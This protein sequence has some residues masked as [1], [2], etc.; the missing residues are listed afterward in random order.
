M[1]LGQGHKVADFYGIPG[2]YL[3]LLCDVIRQLGLDEQE[4][5]HDLGVTRSELLRPD[6]RISMKTGH[7]A[8]QRAT[9]LAGD[10]GL[11]MAYAQALKVTLHGSVGLVAMTSPTVGAALHAMCKF[12]ALRAPF[13]K[14]RFE[15][16]AQELVLSLDPTLEMDAP[17]RIF[18]ME[19]L[20][21]GVAIM[22]EQLLGRVPEQAVVKLI[23]PEPPYYTRYR[24]RLPVPVQFQ[25]DHNALH[26]PIEL[27]NAVPQLA[28][29][30]AAELARQQCEQEYQAL[31]PQ[32]ERFADRIARHLAMSAKGQ[33]LPTQED[34]ARRFHL[35]TRTL[36]RRLQ[37]DVTS[38]RELQEQELRQRAQ[39]LL[40]DLSLDISEIAWQLGYREVA[41]F[42]TAF[43]RW[44]GQTPR[45]YR[46]N[47][48]DSSQ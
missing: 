15:T 37:E 25:S 26:A 32:A 46:K 41:N 17:I 13:F 9:V 3:L 6:S 8:A 47:L 20:L 39:S 38:F 34:V 2:I 43:K 28:D 14:A 24:D 7:I 40:Q 5:I 42:S 10:L 27:M 44:S 31:F 21:I 12:V 19:S 11:G 18:M 22:T 30:A 16:N 29:P 33:P 45:A 1:N 35:S 23:G 4:V 36:K 48:G